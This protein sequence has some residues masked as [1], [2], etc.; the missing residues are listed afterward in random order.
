[1]FLIEI[2]LLI[3]LGGTI[4]FQFILSFA[5]KFLKI[6]EPYSAL[7]KK[8]KIAILIPAYKEDGVILSVA[9]ES[10]KQNYPREFYEIFII[11]DQLKS[12][13]V[14]KLRE[15]G[16]QVIEVF[17][18]KS[19]KVKSLNLALSEI[20]GFEIALILDAD[21]VMRYDFLD[22]INGCYNAGYKA[23]QGKRVA[24]NSNT[25]FAVLDGLS[26]EI[27]NNVF[28]KG[29]AAL[30]VSSPII[31][32][33]MAFNFQIIKEVLREIGA[34]GGF[35]R[36]LQI[37]VIDRGLTIQYLPSAWVFDEKVQNAQVF[38]NQRKR[39]ISSQFVY[40]RKYFLSG[41]SGLFKGKVEY[42]IFTVVYNIMLPR[43][44]MLL[45]TTLCA[46]AFLWID[47]EFNFRSLTYF[48]LWVAYLLSIAFAIP[49]ELYSFKTFKALSSLPSAVLKMITNI[50][51]MKGANKEFIHT[52]H[53]SMAI[54][55]KLSN[56]DK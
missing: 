23:I 30:G 22:R 43:I 16:V 1:M 29:S 40:L 10:L 25:N 44:L 20:S 21:N 11:A 39:W 15:I 49:A 24:K 6:V 37:K 47:K 41:F 14:F 54:D 42:F 5:G 35:D 53:T 52:P 4:T 3:Y 36:E 32:S 56:N 13:T 48:W 51:K 55:Q 27:N 38:E 34:V 8:N 19:T 9:E 45:T 28:R 33:G 31:G 7:T 46:L 50:F 26:E 17:F 18:E 2:I 12:T